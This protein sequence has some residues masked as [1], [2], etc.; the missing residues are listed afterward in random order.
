MLLPTDDDT[1]AILTMTRSELEQ[2]LI[3]TQIELDSCACQL[4]DVE[5]T[6]AQNSVLDD[7]H[8]LQIWKAFYKKYLTM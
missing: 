7:I 2:L 5:G 8:E 3:G 6:E 1:S 4:Y